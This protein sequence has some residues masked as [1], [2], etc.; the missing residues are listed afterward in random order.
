MTYFLLFGNE[1]DKKLILDLLANATIYDFNNIENY[2]DIRTKMLNE[3]LPDNLIDYG[4]YNDFRIKGQIEKNRSNLEGPYK[5]VFHIFNEKNQFFELPTI[6]FGIVGS[7][8]YIYAVQNKSKI[9]PSDFSKMVDKYFRKINKGVPQDIIESNISPN[10]LVSLTL[11]LS[12]LKKNHITKIIS[13]AYLPIRYQSSKISKLHMAKDKQAI[14]E[15][16]EKHNRDQFN[17]TNKLMYLMLRYNF[18]FPNCDCN[19]DNSTELMSLN[20]KKSIPINDNIIYKL[21]ELLDN[22]YIK[23]GNISENEKEFSL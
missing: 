3:K 20:L 21:D 23:N 15:A 14:Y 9:I 19:F 6:T 4:Q 22:Y 17:I 11:F 16:M 13:P 1:F 18:H 5:I 2:L 8:C 10:A 12:L 7:D